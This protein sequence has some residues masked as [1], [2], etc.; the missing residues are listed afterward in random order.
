MCGERCVYVARVNV[1][2]PDEL[3]EELRAT[4]LNLS[5]VTRMA[6]HRE[7]ARWRTAVN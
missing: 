1:Y 5:V 2:L 6:V 4:R 3:I 7:L